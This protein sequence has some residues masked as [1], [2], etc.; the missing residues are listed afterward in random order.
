MLYEFKFAKLVLLSI[1]IFRCSNASNSR[2]FHHQGC[3]L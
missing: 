2:L 1:L 3:A